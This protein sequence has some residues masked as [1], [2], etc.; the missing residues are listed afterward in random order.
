MNR[1]LGRPTRWCKQ[2]CIFLGGIQ[3]LA[4]YS[5]VAQLCTFGIITNHFS[6]AELKRYTK[7]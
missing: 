2:L 4:T 6:R 7:Q 5:A 3:Y 1:Y